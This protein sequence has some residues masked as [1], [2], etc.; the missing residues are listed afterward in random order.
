MIF[1]KME[2]NIKNILLKLKLGQIRNSMI[3]KY[4]LNIFIQAK[5]TILMMS[6][7]MN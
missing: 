3:I 5:N 6:Q 7:K 1:I 4:I 2:I